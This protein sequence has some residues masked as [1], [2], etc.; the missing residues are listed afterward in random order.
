VEHPMPLQEPGSSSS[1]LRGPTLFLAEHP[2]AYW[3]SLVAAS[4]ALALFVHRAATAR[5][6]QRWLWYALSGE[7]LV[8]VLGLAT[9]RLR[10]HRGST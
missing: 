3:L 5:G 10:A 8:Q 4:A 1:G 2:T 7:Q 9:L 6:R